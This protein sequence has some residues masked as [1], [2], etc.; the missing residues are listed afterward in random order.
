M[1]DDAA[2]PQIHKSTTDRLVYMANQIS[3][4]FI[5]QG[6]AE[7]AVL[8]V[9]DHIKSFWDPSMIRRIYAHLDAT[10]G[11]GLNPVALEAVRTVRKASPHAMQSALERMG[12]HT[13]EDEGD[14]AG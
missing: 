13:G 9:A 11:E 1:E 12:V 6:T 8:G 14:D 10:G 5:S 3:S 4:F 7:R 2:E